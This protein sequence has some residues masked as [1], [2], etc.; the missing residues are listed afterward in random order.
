MTH[1][2]KFLSTTCTNIFAFTYTQYE[3]L[4]Y[5]FSLNRSGLPLP[6]LPQDHVGCR[7]RVRTVKTM[8]RKKRM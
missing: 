3:D 5:P 2:I 8:T 6:P 4:N 1:A 7:V